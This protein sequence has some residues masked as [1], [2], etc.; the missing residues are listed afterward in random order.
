MCALAPITRNRQRDRVH[1]VLSMLFVAAFVTAGRGGAGVTIAPDQV[2]LP[3]PDH[4]L[5]VVLENKDVGQI[6]GS[7]DAPYL[8]SLAAGS[9][10][11]V[12]AYAETHPSQ[13]N[14]LAL[15]SGDTQGVTDDSCMTSPFSTPSLGGRLLTT[16]RT[17]VGYAEGLPAVGYAGCADADYAR[18]H[19]PWVNFVD[20]PPAA[21]RPLSDL[22]ADYVDLPTV[23]F[24][25]PNMCHDMHDCDVA[26]GD[27]W[28]R[29]NIGRYADWALTHNSMLVVTFDESASSG[30]ENGI[31]T[32][33]SGAMVRPGTYDEPVDHY[34]LLRTITDMYRLPPLGRSAHAGPIT[35][36]WREPV[37]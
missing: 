36:A 2:V 18:K 24:L 33:M 17:F 22:P 30:Q 7:P 25:I 8:N 26:T 20:V 27:A 13:P 5:I 23:A 6:L 21:S 35:D 37:G 1:V 19:N 12:H 10:T 3:V 28:L 34:R 29:E 16:G 31:F 4:V 14:Y 32:V 15:F 11:F 9:A